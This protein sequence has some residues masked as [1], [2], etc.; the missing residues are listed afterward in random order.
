MHGIFLP[1]PMF[2]EY[3]VSLDG[4]VFSTKSNKILTP[5]T[6]NYGY[7]S[8]RLHRNGR[9][10]NTGIHRIIACA[11]KRL[12]SLDS[13]LEVDHIDTDITYWGL[14][15]LQVLT[16]EQHLEKTLKDKSYNKLIHNK[17]CSICGEPISLKADKCQKCS[18]HKL[19]DP[20][21]T[22]EIIESAVKELGWSSAGRKLSY[23][24]NGLRK[25]YKA[26]GGDP[27]ELKKL[28]VL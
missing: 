6:S 21:I 11:F 28:K 14:N 22:K 27:K 10:R 20:S 3:L 16:K 4:L 7:V 5:I 24:D 9:Q 8:V 1:I 13:V 2:E 23:S 17:Q 25:R 15:N 12:P 19:K 18:S 26:L